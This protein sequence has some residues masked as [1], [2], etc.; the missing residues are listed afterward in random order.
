MASDID[1]NIARN[2]GVFVSDRFFDQEASKI[3]LPPPTALDKTFWM[4]FFGRISDSY[5]VP[6]ATYFAHQYD[7]RRWNDLYHKYKLCEK[8]KEYEKNNN[9]K[10]KDRKRLKMHEVLVETI[11]EWLDTGRDYIE[12][13]QNNIEVIAKEGDQGIYKALCAELYYT[14]KIALPFLSIANYRLINKFLDSIKLG[15]D[16]EKAAANIG[17]PL[18]KIDEWIETGREDIARG[19]D[20]ALSTFVKDIEKHFA[21]REIKLLSKYE[22]AMDGKP[23]AIMDLL[24]VVNPERYHD[25]FAIQQEALRIN[26]EQMKLVHEALEKV[27]DEETYNKVLLQFR[28]LGF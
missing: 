16:I 14:Y 5:K 23:K 12:L 3:K 27:L 13:K 19:R 1:S 24:K 15:L 8:Y 22:E 11:Q 26:A 10:G 18:S 21:Q 7:P 20:T 2:G 28:N 25:K 9:E 6:E 17:V 4:I